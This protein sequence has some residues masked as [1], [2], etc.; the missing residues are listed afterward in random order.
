MKSRGSGLD[1]TVVSK[2]ASVTV[3]VI[4]P[5]TRPMYGGRTGTRPSEGLSAKMPQCVAGGRSA[6]LI[7]V[8]IW[9]G[10]KQATA[11]APSPEL[12]PEVLRSR[13]QGL[14]VTPCRLDR[15]E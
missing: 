1:S 8:L 14:R 11:A 13:R 6:R 5:A 7:S 9:R 10:A 4:G 12:E 2:A 3:R 15:P